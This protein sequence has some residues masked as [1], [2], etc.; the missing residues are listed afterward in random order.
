MSETYRGSKSTA[1]ISSN[2][3]RRSLRVHGCF[4]IRICGLDESGREFRTDSLADNISADGLYV[5]IIRHVARGSKLFVMVQLT[6]GATIAA[7]GLASRVEQRPH[8]LWGISI[9]FTRARLLPW[10][11]IAMLSPSTGTV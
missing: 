11:G 5:Q 2:N 10:Q 4:P 8:G 1:G 6:S 9:H 3:N 7:R